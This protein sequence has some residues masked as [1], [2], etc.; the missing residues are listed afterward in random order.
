MCISFC[1]C[2]D[3]NNEDEIL[4]MYTDEINILY[5]PK[6]SNLLQIKGKILRYFCL[7]FQLCLKIRH[8]WSIRIPVYSAQL[9]SQLSKFRI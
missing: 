9:L 4:I 5:T 1:K 6:T 3:T 7:Y 8:F 2:Q